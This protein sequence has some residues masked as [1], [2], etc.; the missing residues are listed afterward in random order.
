MRDNLF[1]DTTLDSSKPNI[2]NLSM[3]YPQ[4]RNAMEELLRYAS[5]EPEEV[6]EHLRILTDRV[7]NVES[8]RVE[9]A[10]PTKEISYPTI[11]N[12]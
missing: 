9:V 1:I 5:N 11:V 10:N 3:P 12:L 4:R 7:K 2:L 8:F 6:R